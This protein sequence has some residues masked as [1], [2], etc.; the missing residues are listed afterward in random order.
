MAARQS[1]WLA[2]RVTWLTLR[3]AIYQT[4]AGDRPVIDS[5]IRMSLWKRAVGKMLVSYLAPCSPSCARAAACRPEARLRLRSLPHE[6]QMAG[7]VPRGEQQV[8]ERNRSVY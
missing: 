7:C 8:E 4:L 5:V 6:S 3:A 1:T 2:L